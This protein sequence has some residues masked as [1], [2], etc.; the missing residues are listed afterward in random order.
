MM[1]MEQ[2][3][4][5]MHTDSPASRWW[6]W[7]A[8]RNFGKTEEERELMS[9]GNDAA[10]TFTT[11]TTT[12][13]EYS[14]QAYLEELQRQSAIALHALLWIASVSI[15][16]VLFTHPTAL[17][18]ITHSY[19][20]SPGSDVLEGAMPVTMRRARGLFADVNVPVACLVAQTVAAA[21]LPDRR[22]GGLLVAGTS[23]LLL[24]MQ[25]N[26][27]ISFSALLWLQ[28]V[29]MVTFFAAGSRVRDALL[30]LSMP[31]LAVSA[32]A[33]AGERDSM[34][35]TTVYLALCG[36]PLIWSVFH[37][38]ADSSSD[39]ERWV[40]GAQA[41]MSVIPYFV[42]GGLVLSTTAAPAWAYA[43][44]VFAIVWIGALLV[45]L[46]AWAYLTPATQTGLYILH[47]L[48]HAALLL[49][50]LCGAFISY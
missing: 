2:A 23:I 26:W 25:P 49:L 24:F 38:L 11:T 48:A 30:P 45:G 4:L 22:V 21:L 17:G 42:R 36:M 1:M 35:L 12:S 13:N 5:L 6:E 31:V 40:L 46:S 8:A 20:L 47:Q 41:W 34:G 28:L 32:L 16:S 15:V 50:L 43:G 44:L 39:G 9:I 10:T 7:S 27:H 29:L 33:M 18:S 3:P 19:T 37:R 14:E